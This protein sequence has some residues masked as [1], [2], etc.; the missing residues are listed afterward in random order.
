MNNGSARIIE[1][2]RGGFCWSWVRFVACR[3]SKRIL[4]RRLRRLRRLFADWMS[5]DGL[6]LLGASVSEKFKS[7]A[8]ALVCWTRLVWRNFRCRRE[9]GEDSACS[10][11]VKNLTEA[12]RH[13]GN[14]FLPP[15]GGAQSDQ[16]KIMV[17]LMSAGKRWVKSS[18]CRGCF[19]CASCGV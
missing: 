18:D 15:R 13:R 4:V 12:P 5:G 8:V 9:G 10:G 1:K 19:F 16:S 3:F 14:C 2:R 6:C 7:I 11:N 17:L